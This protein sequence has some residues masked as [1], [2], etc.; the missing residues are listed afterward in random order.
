[1]FRLVIPLAAGIFFADT[2]RLEIRGVA[3]DAYAFIIGV[4]GCLAEGFSL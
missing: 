4:A 1:M 3:G 2:F